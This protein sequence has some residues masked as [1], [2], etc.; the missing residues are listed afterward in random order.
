M[1]IMCRWTGLDYS[2][3]VLGLVTGWHFVFV[4]FPHVQP[5][6]F[7]LLVFWFILVYFFFVQYPPTGL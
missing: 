6:F 4:S 1:L 3:T 2:G 5:L 7:F